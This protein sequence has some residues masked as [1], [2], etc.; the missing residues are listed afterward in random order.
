[1]AS[2]KTNK[3]KSS[4]PIK[5]REQRLAEEKVLKAAARR[6]AMITLIAVVSV[7]VLLAGSLIGILVARNIK[8]NKETPGFKPNGTIKD[9]VYVKMTVKDYGDIV[10]KL[11]GEEAPITVANFV[12]LVNSGFYD[13]LTFHRVI[14]DFMIQGGDPNADGSG[15]SENKIKGE[16]ESNGYHNCI[17]HERGVISMARNSASKDSASSQFFICNT[18]GESVSHLDGEYAAFGHVIYG[19]NVVDLITTKTGPYATDMN[20]SI[21]KADQAVITSMVVL[22]KSEAKKYL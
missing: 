9:T 7:I 4:S 21:A 15:G 22:S 2:K 6:K 1:M 20:G 14:E 17:A 5:T 19:M 13:G 12:S 16:F 3:K 18:S 8:A 11:N 10:L